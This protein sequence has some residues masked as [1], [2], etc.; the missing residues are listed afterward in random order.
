MNIQQHRNQCNYNES[1]INW[2]KVNKFIFN[3]WLITIA[4]YT[5]LHKIDF[6]LH[7]KAKLTDQEITKFI[8]TRGRKFTGHGARNSR[9]IYYFRSISADYIDLYTESRRVRYNQINLNQITDVELN[10]YLD[11]WFKVI[12]PFTP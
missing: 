10:Q 12:K 1:I 4:F 9:I 5:A 3:D 7:K 2:G 11:I 6:C 8:N